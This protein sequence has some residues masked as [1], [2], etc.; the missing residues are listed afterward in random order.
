MKQILNQV[1]YGAQ[2]YVKCNA[3]SILS[4]FA[5]GGV[6]GTSVSVVK[7]TNKFTDKKKESSSMKE[8]IC[9]AIPIFLPAV[10]LGSSTIVCILGA[11]HINKQK[12]AALLSAYALI[13]QSFK[14][15]RT[16]LIELQGEDL[17]T[18]IQEDLYRAGLSQCVHTDE[19]GKLEWFEPFSKETLY[20]YEKE[21]I[22]AEYQLN[23][24][25]TGRGYATLNDWYDILGLPHTPYGDALGWGICCDYAWVDFEHHLID[26]MS[27]TFYSIGYPIPPTQEWYDDHLPFL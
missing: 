27:G 12:Q 3:A 13:D 1:F 11:N 9:I 26:N 4:L 5:V 18:K 10:L 24:L 15:Y 19:D 20:L 16:K 21:I 8:T 25:F 23:R 6:I 2:K 14:D 7:A 17:N 22:D